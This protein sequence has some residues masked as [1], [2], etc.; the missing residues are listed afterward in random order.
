[1]LHRKNCHKSC[2]GLHHHMTSYKNVFEKTSAWQ[3]PA[4][5]AIF[6]MNI[7]SWSG[8]PRRTYVMLFILAVISVLLSLRLLGNT[9]QHTFQTLHIL[10]WW[11]H[12]L[13]RICLRWL[14][15]L[16]ILEIRDS[17]ECASQNGWEE[18]GEGRV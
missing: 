1:M 15:Y 18:W 17:K 12:C 13:W 8:Y 10:E 14:F 2:L 9:C 7:S 6:V 11:T 4:C 16:S 5:L 3:L